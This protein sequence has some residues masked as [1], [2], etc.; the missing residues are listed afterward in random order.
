MP[1]SIDLRLSGTRTIPSTGG[2]WDWSDIRQANYFLEHCNAAD[3]DPENI[4]VYIAEVKFFKAVLYFDKVKTFGD[5]PWLNSS[6]N[7]ESPE[8]FAPRDKRNVVVDSIISLL[9]YAI[10]NLKPKSQ[11]LNLSGLTVKLQFL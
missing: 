6:L 8:L 3:D 9:D 5:V 7:T 11:P 4:K 2:G 10:E 1:G